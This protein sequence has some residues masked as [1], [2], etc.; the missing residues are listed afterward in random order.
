[1]R[2]QQS[3]PYSIT[4]L[5]PY[6][7][8]RWWYRL[9]APK[10]P[11]RAEE[12][13]L[14]E[15]EFLRRG[16]L[17]S[18]ALLIQLVE[19]VVQMIPAS[20]DGTNSL[21]AILMSTAFV[22]IAVFLNR[23]GKLLWAGLLVIAV[24]EVGMFS[25]VTFRGVLDIS[26]IPLVF[27]LTQPLLVSVLLFPSWGVLVMAAVNMAMTALILLLFPKT[28]EFQAFLQANAGP[29]FGVPLTLQLLC[30]LVC[31][32][33]I[34]SLQE[35]LIR[36]DRAEEV[37]RLQKVMAEQARQELQAKRQLET[38]IQEIIT[39]LTRFSNGDNQTRIQLEQGSPLWPIAGSINNIVSR[40]VRLREQERPMEL[41]MLAL[42]AYLR[43][44]QMA[45]TTGKPLSLP[46]T[47]TEMDNL[48]RELL[49]YAGAQQSQQ[50]GRTPGSW[51]GV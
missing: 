17:T 45:R 39:G 20:H 22:I 50:G 5:N 46:Y 14:K 1:M 9:A 24:L 13:P 21:P 6:P 25:V 28:P 35:S 18:I 38:N 31:Y 43:E 27:I 2:S 37:T 26:K 44:I 19:L 51:P 42:R 40:F 23:A 4:G 32:I 15:R 7:W 16:K 29:M 36:A 47:G 10:V 11:P 12:L 49:Q 30:A 48:V 8:I 41:T 34:T 3:S 33:V